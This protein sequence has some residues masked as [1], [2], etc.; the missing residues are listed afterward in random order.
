MNPSHAISGPEFPRDIAETADSPVLRLAHLPGGTGNASIR[1]M[2]ER[3]GLSL[4]AVTPGHAI[5]GSYWGDEE[6]GL[7]GDRLFARPDTPVHSV[8]HEASHYVCMDPARRA[9]LDTDAGGDDQEENAV[10]YLQILLADQV[11]GF[12][13]ERVL[14]DMDAWGY[15]FRLGSARRWF[16]ED[17]DDAHR[18]LLREGLIDAAG[19]PTGRLRAAD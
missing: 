19:V 1:S 14:A 12:G 18:W 9:T 5:P 6:A 4:H 15:S 11:E 13:R 8:L 3:F 2:L 10:C 16:R 17:A 7:R